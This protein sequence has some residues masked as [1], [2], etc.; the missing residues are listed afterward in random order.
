MLQTKID[1][2][3]L[4]SMEK[5]SING[6]RLCLFFGANPNQDV[7][8]VDRPGYH[9]VTRATRSGQSQIL[10]LLLQYG[11]DPNAYSSG[12]PTI[13]P[14]HMAVVKEQASCVKVLIEFGADVH[15]KCKLN[16]NDKWY[17]PLELARHLG[18]SVVISEFSM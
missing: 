2:L 17:S 11:G 13:A 15:Q 14:L 5:F 9:L 10:K 4:L 6:V 18:K 16:G 3:L 12:F 1:G 8:F 7:G